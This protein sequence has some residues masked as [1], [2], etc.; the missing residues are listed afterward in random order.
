M[1]WTSSALPVA[2]GSLTALML[3]QITPSMTNRSSPHTLPSGMPC[4]CHTS[5][6]VVASRTSRPL[7]ARP[8][9]HPSQATS[10]RAAPLLGSTFQRPRPVLRSRHSSD[11]PAWNMTLPPSMASETPLR[12]VTLFCHRTLPFSPLTAV[13]LPAGLAAGPA[14]PLRFSASDWAA[15]D[16]YTTATPSETAIC[17]AGAVSE[18][19]ARTLP[20]A[21][22]SIDRGAW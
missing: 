6:P 14:L 4:L 3:G 1:A 20:V 7:A 18:T 11:F 5:L 8:M 9:T 15:L 13:S 12:P 21:A 10:V 2:P 19:V 22:S 16:E 17:R